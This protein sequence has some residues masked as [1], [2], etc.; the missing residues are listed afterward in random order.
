MLL[1]VDNLAV[2]YRGSPQPAVAGVSFS[3]GRG[4]S[5]GMV[6]ASGSGKTQ[7][8]LAIM[9][10]LPAHAEVSGS[11][12]C[13]GAE[14]LGLPERELNRFRA[15]RIGMVFQ[16]PASAL[17][18]CLT[19]GR[20]LALVLCTHG[21]ARR[22]RWRPAAAALLERVR[23]PEPQRLLD[24]YPHQL[25][26][27]MR[28]R[29]MIALALAAEPDL[30]I[31]DE[32][33]TALDVTVQAGILAVLRELEARAGIGLLLITHDLGV[34][35]EN[36]ERMLVLHGGRCV[37]AGR[38]ADVFRASAAPHTRAL[39]AAAPRLDGPQARRSPRDGQPPLLA[40]EHVT[41]SYADGAGRARMAAEDVSLTV[42]RGETL[43]IVGES[44]SGKTTLA[45]A[46]T[47]L[48]APDA[49]RV[50][51]AGAVLPAAARDRPPALRRRVQMVF[52]DPAGS[53]DPAMTVREILDEPLRYAESRRDKAT[54]AAAAAALLARV[55]L[56]ATLL[57]RRPHEL[58]NGQAQ[59][60]ALARALAC[61]PAVLV[62]DEA[63][64]ALDGTARAEILSLLAHEQEATGLA[65]VFITHDLAVVRGIAHRI[66][67]MQ[68]G[69]ICELADAESLFRQPRHP[70]TRALLDAVPVPDPDARRGP[71]VHDSSA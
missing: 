37:E 54:R 32:P 41:V 31:A 24:V 12:R 10:L 43:G 7:T 42:A 40:L 18:P 34:I 17:N 56:D 14:L 66:A 8:A 69:R 26:G 65:L 36:T 61:D 59:R 29:A 4:E 50:T 23:L 27:G 68:A 9:G 6:G 28:Q 63:V 70:Y 25:S 49:G 39:I 21:V 60:V 45:R 20:Q 67:V 11:V 58:S 38:T 13:D 51:L 47:G 22:G 52:Q 15:R 19:I 3:L 30:L 64:A 62:C 57:E 44:G 1:E 16:D 35:A 53:L 55:R 48:R 46:I 33:T 71:L 2:R 5:L